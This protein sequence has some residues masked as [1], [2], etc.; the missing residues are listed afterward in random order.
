MIGGV[1]LMI[2]IPLLAVNFPANANMLVN[3]LLMIANFDIPYFNMD[4]ILGPTLWNLG[5]DDS[6]LGDMTNDGALI[7]RLSEL[8]YNTRYL[9]RFMGSV[10]IIMVGSICILLVIGLLQLCK[11]NKHLGKIESY[12]NKKFLWNFYISLVSQPTL[13]LTIS[14]YFNLKYGNLAKD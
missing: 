5:D 13:E 7:G 14:G 2:S 8:G 11:K 10:Y 1:Q 6:V 9:S 3:N 12:L 4:D